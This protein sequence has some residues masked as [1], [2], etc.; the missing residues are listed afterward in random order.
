MHHLNRWSG[1][2]ASSAEDGD[3]EDDGESHSGGDVFPAPGDDP[4]FDRS[5]GGGLLEYSYLNAP[6]R[7]KEFVR[8]VWTL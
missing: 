2:G 6:G 4:S 1:L 8:H 5:K 7:S 3:G